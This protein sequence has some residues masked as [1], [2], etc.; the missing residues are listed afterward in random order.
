MS[1]GDERGFL[2]ALEEAP[3]DDTTWLVYA[4]WLEERG[5]PRSEYL[6]LTIDIA[7]GAVEPAVLLE[8]SERS[9]RPLDVTFM[10]ATEA[11]TSTTFL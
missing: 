11:G 5:D 1:G 2:T 9:P 6:R 7:R 8:A 3:A 4:D 10:L